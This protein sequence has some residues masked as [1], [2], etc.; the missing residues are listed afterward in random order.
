MEAVQGR[1]RLAAALLLAAFGAAA[2]STASGATPVEDPAH[3]SAL[4]LGVSGS[5]FA[6]EISVSLDGTQTQYVVTS[7]RL[8]NP[9]PPPCNQISDSQISCPTSDFV[10]FEVHLGK[11][12]D[13]FTVGPSIRVPVS[14]SGGPGRDL[15]R[16]GSGD[17]TLRGGAGGDRLFGNN[18][19]DVLRGAKG[20]DVLTG[21]KGRDELI[22]GAGRDAL[23]G[24]QGRDVE[25]Q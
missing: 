13:S 10:A 9:P 16:G 12:R 4:Q 7:T 1:G 20:G 3:S 2:V 8:I 21:G 19:R 25:K 5:P 14:I 23:R 11:G 6:D 15:L 22:G 18:G 17:D 24:G